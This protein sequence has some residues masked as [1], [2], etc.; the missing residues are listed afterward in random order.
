[1][2][3][4][5]ELL[6]DAFVAH[7][8][9]IAD[10]DD[11]L[12]KVDA[13]AR[14]HRRNRWA[15]RATGA[16][17]VTAGLVVGAIA[18]PGLVSS[19]HNGSTVLST[20][21]HGAKAQTSST[22]GYSTDQDENAFLNAG[23]DYQDAQHLA[24]LWSETNIGQV[25]AEAGAKLLAGEKLPVKPS[26][27]PVPAENTG[28]SA[29]FADGYTYNDAVK[30]SKIWH[31]SSYQAKIK[32]G[33]ELAAGKTLP[34]EPSGPKDPAAGSVGATSISPA[35]KAAMARKLSLLKKAGKVIAVP[36]G[37]SSTAGSDAMSPALTKYFDAGYDYNNAVDL[38]KIWH[39]T[40]I[41][42]IKSEAGQ[43]LLDGETLPVKPDSTPAPP[44]NAA[45]DQAV[46]TFFN[47]GYGYNDA[48]KLGK[49]W[50]VDSYHAKIEGGKKLE[51]GQTLPVSPT[52]N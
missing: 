25:K 48:V 51:A 12:A 29:F 46:T 52:G 5:N 24:K 31:V 10:T 19:G 43:K 23:Y 6:T 15:V 7:T 14:T 20:A 8:Q 50:N 4:E 9:A 35:G 18:L 36:N 33:K 2:F 42:K 1:M 3:E 30:L 28:V 22:G 39:Q 49:I 38:G 34:V 11:V 32:G 13:L 37:D 41:S 40:D 44:D 26:G 17:L 45:D 21:G 27:Q 16:S 47:D